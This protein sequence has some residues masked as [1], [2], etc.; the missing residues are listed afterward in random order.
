MT[1]T[2]TAP[3]ANPVEGPINQGPS[4][5]TVAGR[6]LRFAFA[7]LRLGPVLILLVIAL[8]AS[9]SSPYFL[10]E[11]NLQNLGAQTASTA[12][13]AVGQ[14][15]VVVT[16]GIDLSVG[17]AVSLCTVIGA[18]AFIDGYPPAVVMAAMTLIGVS[19]GFVNGALLVMTRIPHPFIITLGTMNMTLGVGLLVSGGVA[20][21]GMP[22][23]IKTI[24][25]GYVLSVPVTV[26]LALGWALM[27]GV[28]ARDLKW[29]RWI[30]AVGGNP[31]AAARAGIPVSRIIVST[32]VLSGL[33]ASVAALIIAGRT[34]AGDPVAG[35]LLELDAIA[36]VIIGGASFFGGRGSVVGA[37]AGALVIGVIRNAL[38]LMN[39]SPYL[40]LIAIGSIII[41]AVLLDVL[42]IRLETRV[43]SM[44]A[45]GAS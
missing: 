4:R 33:S 16:R 26:L 27:V 14:L 30:F 13:L 11:R 3:Y 43:R 5:P 32:Y 38:N 19:I 8:I 25:T 17:S 45:E 28:L 29:G 7:L 2:S 22:S 31:E 12:V 15:L 40:Q 10:T 1:L 6:L 9:V 20:V 23:P 39:V 24:G 37:V 44:Q 42:R 36:A 35:S 21:V 34:N 18:L 41:L